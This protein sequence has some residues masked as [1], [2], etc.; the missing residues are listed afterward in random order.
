MAKRMNGGVLRNIGIVVG[1][2]LAIGSII[3]AFAIQSGSLTHIESDIVEVKR[4]AK[5]VNNRVDKVEDAVILIQS[6]I[7][8]IQRDVAKI[9]KEVEKDE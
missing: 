7:S 1:I 2:L 5:I 8:Y 6:D 3:W 9:L 4:E